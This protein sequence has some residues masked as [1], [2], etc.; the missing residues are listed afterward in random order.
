MALPG[1]I[2][3]SAPALGTGLMGLGTYGACRTPG[4]RSGRGLRS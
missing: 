4:L 3:G 1:D 2:R